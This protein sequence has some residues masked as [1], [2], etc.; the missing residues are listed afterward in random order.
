[1]LEL[2][3]DDQQLIGRFL[4][5]LW[6]EEGLAVQSRAGYGSDLRGYARWLFQRGECLSQAGKQS[7]LAY[8]SERVGAGARP[9]TT[10][11]LLSSLRR[12]YRWQ[13][14]ERLT[15]QD[16]TTDVALPQVGR[17]LPRPL[18]EQAVDRL[19]AAPDV[20]TALGQRDKAMLEVLYGSGLRV[21]E[22]ITLGMDQV[23]L[24]QGVVRV[25]GKG[26]KNR[27]VPMGECALDWVQRY[28]EQARPLLL[29]HRISSALFVTARG[30][31]MTRQAFWFRIRHYAVQAGFDGSLSPHTLRHTFATHLLNHGADL[32]AVQLLLGHDNLSA[33][34]IYTHVAT[35]RLQDLHREHHPRG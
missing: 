5:A 30:G 4:D 21:S 28:L 34:Q 13:R 9:R 23:D 33:T 3:D 15:D 12:F 16:P 1:V 14:R 8:L 6:L 19:L 10:A 2:D 17:L 18:G 27:L 29:K 31:A 11:R 25:H 22:L 35:Q 7:L 32:R 26:G 20:A 24:Y